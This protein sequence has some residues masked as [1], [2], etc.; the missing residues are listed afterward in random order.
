M[1]SIA[2]GLG[3]AAT[4]MALAAA[5]AVTGV[6]AA[7]A[8]PTGAARLYAPS[9]LVLTLVDGDT[10]TEGTILRAVTL[11]CRPGPSGTHPDPKGACDELR[12]RG[13]E[14]D[15]ITRSGSTAMCTR[16]WMPMTVTVD[17]VWEGT[18]VAYTHTFANR[19]DLEH[20]SGTVFTF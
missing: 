7:D 9:A 8:A 3:L 2:R 12:A 13:G 15:S 1:R 17:G 11:S 4:T 6:G 20:G 5:T 18:R 14:F 16:E 10:P 19:C